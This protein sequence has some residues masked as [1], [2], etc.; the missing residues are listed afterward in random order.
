[1]IIGVDIDGV[2]S[3][4]SKFVY[5]FGLKYMKA[6]PELGIKVKNRNGYLFQH[7]FDIPE[8]AEV[9]F[10]REHIPDYL[11]YAKPIKGSVKYLNKLVEEGHKIYILT[12]RKY[13]DGFGYYDNEVQDMT[14][15]WLD[16][17]KIPY[18]KFF[19]DEKNKRLICEEYEIDYLVDDSPG[20]AKNVEPITKCIMFT[21]PYNKS[22]PAKLRADSWKEVY[23]I[24]KNANKK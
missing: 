22:F 13:D 19:C 17:Y 4:Y 15:D 10:W 24:I 6:H 2:L 23:K 20:N 7:I 1:M 16:Y 8:G 12:A 21:Q 14:M 9:D 5:K 11:S 3:D 18:D